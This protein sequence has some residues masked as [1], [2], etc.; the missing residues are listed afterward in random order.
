MR[1]CVGRRCGIEY[2][3]HA[4]VEPEHAR[5]DARDDGWYEGLILVP[6][7]RAAGVLVV[8]EVDA[9]RAR[10][11]LGSPLK[12]DAATLA[13]PA[14]PGHPKIMVGGKS[15]DAIQVARVGANGLRQFRTRQVPP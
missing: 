11:V 3:S 10:H 8:V 1:I 15:P 5:E 4:I 7:I 9:E 2:V 12:P 6:A 14:C 13:L